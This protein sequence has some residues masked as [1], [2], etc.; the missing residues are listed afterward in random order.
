MKQKKPLSFFKSFSIGVKDGILILIILAVI[1]PFV[2]QEVLQRTSSIS[3]LVVVGSVD[4]ELPIRP[5]TPIATLAPTSVPTSMP[6]TIPT[7]VP[8]SMPTPRPTDQATPVPTTEAPTKEAPA[9]PQ[10]V[11]DGG[12]I[13]LNIY[14]LGGRPWTQIQWLDRD[15]IWHDVNGW[16]GHLTENNNVLWYVG[17]NHLGTRSAFRWQIYDSEGGSLLATSDE[18]RLPTVAKETVYVIV[19]LAGDSVNNGETNQRNE[20]NENQNVTNR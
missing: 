5:P 3:D 12:F 18:F 16:G 6:T 11:I 9:P 17:S 2:Y 4:N 20:N 7:S 1:S 10:P 13:Q 15:G 19:S 14:G 8:T